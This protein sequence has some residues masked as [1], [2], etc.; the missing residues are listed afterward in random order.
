MNAEDGD[1]SFLLLTLACIYCTAWHL[2]TQGSHMNSHFTARSKHKIQYLKY[3]ES[4]LQLSYSNR[5]PMALGKTFVIS[6]SCQLPVIY[7]VMSPGYKKEPLSVLS[8]TWTFVVM[9]HPLYFRPLKIKSFSS[10]ALYHY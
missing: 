8:K 10:H 6:R 4:T 7:T 1:R 9:S 5:Q 2:I 3:H